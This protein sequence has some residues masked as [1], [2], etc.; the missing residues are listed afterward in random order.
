MNAHIHN[1]IISIDQLNGFL[2]F[3]FDLNFLQ[4]AKFPDAVIH[5]GHII[6]YGQ[7]SQFFERNGLLFRKAIFDG[8]LVVTFKNLVIGIAGKLVFGINKSLV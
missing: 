2:G 7:G 4:S 3:A 8:K 6:A 5:V 1:I